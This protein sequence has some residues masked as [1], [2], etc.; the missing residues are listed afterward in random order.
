MSDRAS[1]AEAQGPR[2]PS[3]PPVAKRSRGSRGGRS[4]Q[5]K[6]AAWQRLVFIDSLEHSPGAYID[7]SHLPFLRTHGSSRAYKFL[8]PEAAPE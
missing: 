8:A 3:N 5:R 7:P 6:R 4:S 1:A 2:Q